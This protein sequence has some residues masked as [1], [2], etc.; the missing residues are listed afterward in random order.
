MIGYGH[1]RLYNLKNTVGHNLAYFSPYGHYLLNVSYA[2]SIYNNHTNE[3]R[4]NSEPEDRTW[5]VEP[6]FKL[7]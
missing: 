2:D 4:H 7:G 6:W 1:I 5:V 3:F